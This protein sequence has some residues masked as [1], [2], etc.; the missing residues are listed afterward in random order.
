MP[1][2]NISKLLIRNFRSYGDYDTEVDLDSLGPVLIVGEVAGNERK[3][4][5]AGKS[6]IAD[7][8]MWCLFGRLPY[9]QRPGSYVVNKV[10]GKNCLVRITTRDSYQI[11]RTRDMN[12]HSDLLIRTPDGTDVSD[13]TNTNAQQH[14]NRLFSL[15]YDIFCTNVIYP[16]FGMPFLELPDPKRRKAMERMLNL[17]KCDYFA[18]SAKE[19]ASKITELQTGHNA[20]LEAINREIVRITQSIERNID[21]QKQAEVTRAEE[22]KIQEERYDEIDAEFAQ[23]AVRLREQLATAQKTLATIQLYDIDKLRQDWEKHESKLAKLDEADERLQSIVNELTKLR[24]QQAMLE[25]QSFEVV[26]DRRS[27]IKQRIAEANAELSQIKVPDIDQ[28]KKQWAKYDRHQELVEQANQSI[29]QIENR[30]VRTQNEIDAETQRVE[31]LTK[32]T[33]LVCP[34]CGQEISEKHVLGQC[35]PSRDKITELEEQKQKY[36]TELDKITEAKT[37]IEQKVAKPELTIS[38]ANLT[39]KQHESKSAEI[40]LLVESLDNLEIQKRRAEDQ[41]KERLGEITKLQSNIENKDSYVIRKRAE[42]SQARELVVPPEVTIKEAEAVKAQYDAQNKEIKVIEESIA[43]Q[44]SLKQKA[45]DDIQ[46]MIETI[47]KRQNPYEEMIKTQQSDLDGVKTKR[48]ELKKVIER[49][50]QVIRHLDYIRSA[51]SD[52][53]KIK[54]HIL[55]RLI[56]FFNERISYYLDVMDISCSLQFTT[57]LQPKVN[58][59]WP[60]EMWSGGER[61]KIDLALMFAI[62]DLHTSIYDQQCNI[63]VFDEVDGRLDEDG[64][65]KFTEVIFNELAQGQKGTNRTILVIS[66]KDQMRDAFPTKIVVRKDKIGDDGCSHI[67]EVR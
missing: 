12:G 15:D 56:P 16:Q 42:I 41:E 37:K 2:L 58:H 50:D 27:D 25:G 45:K 44:R 52:R 43:D 30:I 11:E 57:A 14:L 9:K 49:H 31:E 39:Q 47:K 32:K 66:H 24:A 33:G 35:E 28:L 18:E 34:T 23:K 20:E 55:S 8:I 38:E 17:N 19:K 40:K 29:T 13:S 3:S 64:I 48:D 54:A 63:L 7:A 4:N 22:I 6:T 10:T 61:K 26:T 21:L 1:I 67:E 60:Y 51:Y 5:G 36:Q 59:Q 53:R 65:G 46:K 62:H